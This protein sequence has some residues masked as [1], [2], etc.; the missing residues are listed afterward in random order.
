[1]KLS[2]YVIG[3]LASND[4]PYIFEVCG[5]A[6]AHLLDSLHGKKEVSAISM[7]H[8]QAAAMAAE[9][10]ARIRQDIGV[11]MATSG[12]GATNMI[13]GIASCFLIQSH[14]YL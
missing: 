10:F 1:M 5:G 11:A 2:D 6:I 13:T 7:H 9:G 8:E 3:F 4:V 12:P 14:V